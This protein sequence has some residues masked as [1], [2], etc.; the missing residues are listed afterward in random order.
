[1]LTP[2]VFNEQ[3]NVAACKLEL[4]VLP[5][6]KQDDWTLHTFLVTQFKRFNVESHIE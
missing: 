5:F 3:T 6:G 1:M 4:V 2:R